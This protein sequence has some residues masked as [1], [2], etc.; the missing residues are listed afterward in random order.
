MIKKYFVTQDTTIN[1]KNNKNA[2]GDSDVLNLF[3]EGAY[4]S[5][6][7]IGSIERKVKRLVIL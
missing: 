1:N 7:K 4:F 5:W 2:V 3:K 6:L